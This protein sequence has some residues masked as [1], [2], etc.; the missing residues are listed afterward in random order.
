MSGYTYVSSEINGIP[1]Q[2][3]WNV[4]YEWFYSYSPE[5]DPNWVYTDKAGHEHW[6]DEG[7][8]KYPTLYEKVTD[9]YW[10][11][12]CHDQHE[13][14]GMFCRWCD[15]Q[16]TPGTR[17][18]DPNGFLVQ[19]TQEITATAHGDLGEEFTA[20]VWDKTIKFKRFSWKI[21]NERYIGE[22]VGIEIYD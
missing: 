13:E 12:D 17:S 11:E 20:E 5:R 15:E 19:T 10:C 21:E 14:Y 9:T 7:E 2:Y 18:P 1:I 22:Y 6:Y 8:K 16:I 4:N 3:N